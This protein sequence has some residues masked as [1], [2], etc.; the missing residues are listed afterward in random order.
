MKAFRLLCRRSRQPLRLASILKQSAHRVLVVVLH[1]FV[2]FLERIVLSQFDIFRYYNNTNSFWPLA[3]VTL[4][5][6][7]RCS[8]VQILCKFERVNM[9]L[10]T[11][12]ENNG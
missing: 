12:D 2:G 11:S 7:Y 10:E 8:A 3:N 6:R 1:C 5:Q 4:M 9:T